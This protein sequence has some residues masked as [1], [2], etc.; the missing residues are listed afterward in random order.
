MQDFET[1]PKIEKAALEPTGIKKRRVPPSRNV[2]TPSSRSGLLSL[3]D[4]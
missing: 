2:L 4:G 1:F 3:E